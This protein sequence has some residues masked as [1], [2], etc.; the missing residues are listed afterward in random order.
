MDPIYE[1][2]GYLDRIKKEGTRMN[3]CGCGGGCGCMDQTAAGPADQPSE[4]VIVYTPDMFGGVGNCGG[5]GDQNG[6]CDCT[7]GQD[8]N[9]GDLVRNIQSGEK[10]RVIDLTEEG[11]IGCVMEGGQCAIMEKTHCT[12]DEKYRVTEGAGCSDK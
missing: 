4:P 3:E 2:N 6:A 1:H 12:I 5:C 7:D 11:R 9:Y 10:G 8:F